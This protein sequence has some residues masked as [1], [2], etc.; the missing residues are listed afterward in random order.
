VCALTRGPVC[1]RAVGAR[2][3]TRGL[4]RLTA[5]VMGALTLTCGPGRVPRPQGEAEPFPGACKVFGHGPRRG[6]VD[7]SVRN[8]DEGG[9]DE[10]G[11]DHA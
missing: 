1:V 10:G 11:G 7:E 9:G 6:L 2:P 8:G 5:A 4:G 3:L